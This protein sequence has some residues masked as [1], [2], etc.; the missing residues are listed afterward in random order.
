EVASRKAISITKASS[1]GL[2]VEADPDQLQLILR[3]LIHNGIKF[4]KAGD[5]VRIAASRSNGHCVVS[6]KD[7]G[8]GMSKEEIDT[9]IGSREHFTKRG[10]QQEKGTGLGLLLCKEFIERNDGTMNIA[11]TTNIGTEVTFTLKLAK[12]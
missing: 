9:I 3:N 2:F 6:I 10:T 4:S 12:V 5:E 1:K 8:I 7:S 11:S